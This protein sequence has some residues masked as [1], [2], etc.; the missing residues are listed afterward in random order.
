MTLDPEQAAIR[1]GFT[2]LV[3]L[4]AM[5]AL[6]VV[7]ALFK[8]AVSRMAPPMEGEEKQKF[9][10]GKVGKWTM[11]VA[12]WAVWLAAL[13]A[14]LHVWG[15]DL[16]SLSEGA[17]GA[18]LSVAGRLAV[19]LVLALATIEGSDFALK[20]MFDRISARA[21]E[22]RRAA[23]LRTLAPLTSAIVRTLVIVVAA[24]M[25]LS[26]FG[27]EVGPL[28]AG[29]GIIG[30]AVG[31]GAQT[32]VKDFLTGFFLIIED[33]VSIGD[34]AKINDTSGTVEEMTLRTIKL[35]QF[36]GTLSVFPYSEA[37]IIHNMTKLFSFYVFDLSIAYSADI[38]KALDVVKQTG[39]ALQNDPEFKQ[40]ILAP[41]EIFGVD[42]L[43]D[44]AVMLKARFKTT[45]IKQWA[46]GREYLKRIKLAFDAAGVE[47]PFPHLKLVAPDEAIAT[48]STKPDGA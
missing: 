1:A 46:V 26:E 21:E 43:A 24:M 9:S 6:F 19:I 5:L 16:Q 39:D 31:F 36:D 47:I 33:S 28:I 44:S 2:F 42:S 15:F 32:L 29:A 38:Q 10:S 25:L 8:A 37:Q 14:V 23:Q 45:P 11:I 13:A 4:G 40:F 20:R 22:P 34:V 27:V 41:I 18:A 12:R 3:L 30:L 48:S 35:R 7:R 17:M